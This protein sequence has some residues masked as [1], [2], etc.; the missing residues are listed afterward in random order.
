MVADNCGRWQI[1]KSLLCWN[2]YA[3]SFI[4]VLFNIFFSTV[5][6]LESRPPSKKTMAGIKQVIEQM[7]K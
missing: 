6:A 3:L 7:F 1:G 5:Q 2:N 4:Q